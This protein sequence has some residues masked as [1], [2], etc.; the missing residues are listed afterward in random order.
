MP[1]LGEHLQVSG[2]LVTGQAGRAE[3]EQTLREIVALVGMETAGIN[4]RTWNF[5]RYRGLFKRAMA[6]LIWFLTGRLISGGLGG[7]GSTTVQPLVESFIVADYWRAHGH[8]FIVLGS[9]K[10]YE[11]RKVVSYLANKFAGV[12]H[13]E[14]FTL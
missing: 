8:W 3:I 4:S 11:P 1:K 2:Y 12:V 7:I 13:R 10:P 6:F 9:C 5:P 14:G